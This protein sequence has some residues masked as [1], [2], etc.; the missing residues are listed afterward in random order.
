LIAGA[1]PPTFEQSVNAQPLTCRRPHLVSWYAFWRRRS[2]CSWGATRMG[3]RA[4]RCTGITARIQV[5]RRRTS[6]RR[7]RRRPCRRMSTLRRRRCWHPKPAGT[8]A[9]F[10]PRRRRLAIPRRCAR[11]IARRAKPPDHLRS[12]PEVRRNDRRHSRAAHRTAR[13][14]VAAV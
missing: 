12:R 8:T 13:E 14:H 2:C 10:N 3:A 11:A 6:V 1:G 7:C 9:E 4:F 5:S